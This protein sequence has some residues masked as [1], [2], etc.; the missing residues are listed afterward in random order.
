MELYSRDSVET[1]SDHRTAHPI[2]RWDISAK[3]VLS[4][5]VVALGLLILFLLFGTA[6][7]LTITDPYQIAK[8]ENSS[9]VG[10]ALIAW[11]LLSTLASIYMGAWYASHIARVGQESALM[12]GFA[13]WS[14]CTIVVALAL[15]HHRFTQ[16]PN[17]N[18]AR[19]FST[20]YGSLSDPE[21]FNFLLMR[22]RN[23][24][25]GTTEQSAAATVDNDVRERANTVTRNLELKHFIQSNT[26]LTKAQTEDFMEQNKIDIYSAQIDAQKRWENKHAVD[27]AEADR[28]KQTVSTLARMFSI[29]A[30]LSL[31][32]ALVGAYVG[33]L[34]RDHPLFHAAHH[35]TLPS[36]VKIA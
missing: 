12:Q 11:V 16:N 6:L 29:V 22:A 9:A 4:G 10:G 17:P 26:N 14:L 21:F 2:W 3:A 15:G 1:L 32:M 13:V 34:S 19:E 36:E 5:A 20:S 30:L 25:P 23:W 31:I 18:H 33:W 27:L 7:G 35:G 28:H 8:G 24:K